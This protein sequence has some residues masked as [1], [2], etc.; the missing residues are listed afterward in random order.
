MRL[1]HPFST[2][3][4]EMSI[5]RELYETELAARNPPI[6]RITEN[7]KKSDT[8]VSY[9]GDDDKPK[10][11]LQKLKDAWDGIGDEDEA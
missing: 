10:S 3:A 7:P 11:A 2:I 6:I 9:M 4:R 8:E 1:V 5:L